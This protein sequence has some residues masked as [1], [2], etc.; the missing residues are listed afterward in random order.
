M[1]LFNLNND[2]KQV[3][4]GLLQDIGTRLINLN[5]SDPSH[6][7]RNIRPQAY[8]TGKFE[9]LKLILEDDFPETDHTQEDK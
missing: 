3:L 9:L 6:D 8:L 1:Q 5:F 2:Q 4:A 7:D